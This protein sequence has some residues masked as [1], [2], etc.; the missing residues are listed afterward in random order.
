[1][2]SETSVIQR[3]VCSTYLL[4]QL[5][6]YFMSQGVFLPWF[7]WLSKK[8]FLCLTGRISYSFLH[9]SHE[10]E[11]ETTDYTNDDTDPNS[12]NP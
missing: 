8:L 2:W 10:G 3:E 9:G 1:M 4:I 7:P 11:G 12:G 5:S 6:L